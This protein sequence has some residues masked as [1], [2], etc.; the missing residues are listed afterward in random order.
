[1]TKHKEITEESQIKNLIKNFNLLRIAEKIE[2]RKTIYNNREVVGEDI[3]DNQS[4][5]SN[6]TLSKHKSSAYVKGLENINKKIADE[7]SLPLE[8]QQL[9]AKQQS[10]ANLKPIEF[11]EYDAKCKKHNLPIN[12]YL[13]G[14]NTLLCEKCPIDSSSSPCPLPRVVKDMKKRID[15][16]LLQ[17]CLIKYEIS[18]LYEFFDSYQ[19]EFDKSNKQKIDDLFSYLY[20]LI[21][22]NYNTAMQIF[23]QCKGEQKTHIDMRIKELN[24]LEKELEE[25]NI[26]LNEVYNQE[27]TSYLKYEKQINDIYERINSFL[28]YETELSLLCMKVGIKNEVKSTIFQTLQD[29]YYIDVEFANIQGD[30][31]TVKHILQKEKFWSCMC[32]ELNNPK[33]EVICVACKTLRRYETIPNFYANPD[34]IGKEDLNTAMLR[35]KIEAK[36]FQDYIKETEALL[37]DGEIFFAIDIEWFLL[38]KCYVTNDAT[39]KNLSNSKKKISVNKQIG[40]LPPGPISNSSLFFKS[41]TKQFEFKSM[42]KGLAKV[43]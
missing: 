5:K 36:I 18:R 22:Y 39:E 15:S 7:K 41:N 13:V 9:S 24:E 26:L 31:P 30:T 35:R 34:K 11:T 27:E 20:K 33:S 1:M 25:L 12:S 14:T 38:W 21:S 8:V 42:R 43:R 28:N 2:V 19:E 4:I 6:L 16:S 17:I 29:S 3:K 37:K 40:V 32:G 23:N 10:S